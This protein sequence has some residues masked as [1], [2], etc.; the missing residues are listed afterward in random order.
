LEG[1]ADF[2]DSLIGG[3]DLTFY[4]MSIGGLLWATIVLK[5]WISSPHNNSLL[6]KQCIRLISFGSSALIVTQLT[7]I[8]LKLWLMTATLG[9]WPLADLMK[10]VQFQ[11]GCLRVFF[12]ILLSLYITKVLNQQ[13]NSKQ[14]WIT[15]LLISLPLIS[16]GA[17]LAHGAS[18]LE[19]SEILMFLSVLHQV[20]AAA[21]IGGVFQLLLLWKLTKQ[22]KINS[23]LWPILLWRFSALGI[24]AVITLISSGL[25]ISLHYFD[26]FNGFI[27]TGYGNLLLVKIL[28]LCVALGFAATNRK[29]VQNYFL[30]QNNYHLTHRIPHYIETE[31][32]VLIT[33]LFTA[34]SLASQP[35]AIDIPNLTATWDQ[36]LNTFAPRIPRLTSPTHEAL[37]AGEAGRT[38]IVGQIASAAAT[39]WSDYN[40]NI[41]GIFLTVMSVFAMLSYYKHTQWAKYWPIGFVALGVFLFFRSD[42]ESWPLGPI[43]F[44]ESTLNNGEV[45]QHRIATL[46]VFMLGTMEIKARLNKK[47]D[48]ILPYVF[49]TLAAFGGLMLLAH[50]HVGFEPKTTFLIQVGHTLMGFFSLI[51]ACGRWLELKLDSPGRELAGFVSVFALFQIGIILMFYREPLY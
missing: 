43:G 21:W 20:S 2:L 44:W 49:P 45:L 12:A 48:S 46:L 50:S 5:P 27:G 31:T 13:I 4:C 32:L 24:I 36:V 11:A 33:I 17:W 42:A 6:L 25:T 16:S 3:I 41:A 26:S 51:L 39:A 22:S 30:S 35:P 1:I 19:N 10:T 47:S 18:R 23:K 37:L 7:K 40:H 9:R 15:A 29:A 8:I 14:H 38:A 34:A 28:M